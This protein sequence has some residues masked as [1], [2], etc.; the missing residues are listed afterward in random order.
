MTNLEE[1]LVCL[2]GGEVLHHD[3][4]HDVLLGGFGEQTHVALLAA[5][6]SEELDRTGRQDVVLCLYIKK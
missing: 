6:R 3:V 5:H 2:G 1:L 4:L